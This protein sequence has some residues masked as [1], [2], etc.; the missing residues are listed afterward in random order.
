MIGVYSFTVAYL[1]GD[2]RIRESWKN[3]G[4]LNKPHTWHSSKSSW[5]LDTIG[6]VPEQL[7]NPYSSNSTNLTS[8]PGM[9]PSSKKRLVVKTLGSALTPVV[10]AS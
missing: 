9:N 5:Q 3:V 6:M 1:R 10:V 2:Q 7:G 4:I 8:L